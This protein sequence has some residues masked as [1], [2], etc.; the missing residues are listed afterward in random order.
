MILSQ[1]LFIFIS[2]H[3]S[4]KEILVEYLICPICKNQFCVKTNRKVGEEIKE[5][6]LTCRRNHKFPIKRGIPRLVV[7]KGKDFIKT[8]NAFF[9]KWKKFR[10][11]SQDKKWYNYQKKWFLERFGWKTTSNFNN[12]L[13]TRHKILDAGTG[14]GNSAKLFSLNRNAEVFA[15]DASG[16]I[17][18]AYKKYGNIPNIYFL[19]ADIRQLPFK[20]SFFDFVCSDQV[21]HHTK[22]TE[23]SFKGLT[24]FLTKNGIISIY[25]YRKK[26]PM[27]EF[28]DDYLRKY[29]VNM[30]ERKCTEFSKD[31]TNLGKSLSKLKRKITIPKDIPLLQIKAG[32]YDVQR[33][34]YWNFLK[35]WWSDDVPPEISIATNFD[36]YYPKYAYRHT[37]KEVRK[38]FKDVKMKI[39]HY[40]E[41]ESGI[42]VTGKK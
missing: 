29:T 6:Y 24:Q 38:W 5:G 20:K 39:I 4:L 12:F 35:C 33:F 37:E 23:T 36:W 19:Q 32:T 3:F 42:S 2:V 34:V 16:S 41:I 26:G 22:N 8:E 1:F 10:K 11:S 14:I 21:L 17:D 13:K 25:V 28:A 30:S 9:K 31:L 27:R 15:I 18:F 40:N 7:D